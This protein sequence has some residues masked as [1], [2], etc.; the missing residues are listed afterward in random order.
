MQALGDPK[1]PLGDV[2]EPVG[3]AAAMLQSRCVFAAALG[4]LPCS[5]GAFELLVGRVF[6]SL[7]PVLACLALGE[8]RGTLERVGDP[9]VERRQ[10]R[11]LACRAPRL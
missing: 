5:L 8:Q 6:P 4:G 2:P 10:L 7:T 3:L 1:A 9:Q 11:V